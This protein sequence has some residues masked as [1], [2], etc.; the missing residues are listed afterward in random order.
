V[1][2]ACAEQLAAIGGGEAP[3]GLP[4]VPRFGE[5]IELP[6]AA[7]ELDDPEVLSKWRDAVAAVAQAR[8]AAVKEAGIREGRE[9]G[10]Q[11]GEARGR[12]QEIGRASCRERV[13]RLV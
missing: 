11:E 2:Q 6:E 13:L 3:A 5:A 1:R 4:E 9:D 12:Q 8:E 7:G 10:V